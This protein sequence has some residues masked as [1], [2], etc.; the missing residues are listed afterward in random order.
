MLAQQSGQI[1][2]IDAAQPAQQAPDRAGAG[3]RAPAGSAA[4][5]R[6]DEKVEEEPAHAPQV[7]LVDLAAQDFFAVKGLDPHADEDQHD[8]DQPGGDDPQGVIVAPE[9]D[10]ALALD[11]QGHGHDD[12]TGQHVG[13]AHAGGLAG[14]DDGAR[15]HHQ[16]GEDVEH[17]D[18]GQQLRVGS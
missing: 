14:D 10:D 6:L 5:G 11:Q 8:D 2:A 9:H 17:N 1:V 7:Q 15:D 4:D 18:L 3:R 12:E 13:G 16:R